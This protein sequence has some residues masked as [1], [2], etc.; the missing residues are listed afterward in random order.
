MRLT[1]KTLSSGEQICA[2]G[3]YSA[4]RN[5]LVPDPKALLHPVKIVKGEPEK[6]DREVQGATTRDSCL[7]CGCLLPLI[8]GAIIGLAVVPLDAI[9]QMFP[10]KNPSWQE[11]EI[12]RWVKREVRP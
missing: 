7:S 2:I 5:A 9:E 6:V 1:E 12:E 3:R 10:N 4:A 8:L 11:I